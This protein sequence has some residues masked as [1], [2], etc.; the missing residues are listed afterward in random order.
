M[1]NFR[2]S[3]L[4]TYHYRLFVL[5]S[6][7][8]Y[9]CRV[10]LKHSLLNVVDSMRPTFTRSHW[11]CTWA[12]SIHISEDT[13]PSSAFRARHLFV[14]AIYTNAHENFWYVWFRSQLFDAPELMVSCEPVFGN[15]MSDNYML[16]HIIIIIILLL[17]LTNLILSLRITT[18]TVDQIWVWDMFT[19]TSGIYSSV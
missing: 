4:T 16:R 13:H 3:I 1:F 6:M 19:A 9:H 2:I 15:Y 10:V 17:K 5:Y 12:K 14:L 11:P 18:R 8:Y 7:F